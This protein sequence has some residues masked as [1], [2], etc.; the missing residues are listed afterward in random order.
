MRTRVWFVVG[1]TVLFGS[2]DMSEAYTIFHRKQVDFWGGQ[3]YPSASDPGA[4]QL[5]GPGIATDGGGLMGAWT[6][7][8]WVKGNL[9]V[10]VM[11]SGLFADMDVASGPLGISSNMVMLSSFLGGLRYDLAH[12]NAPISPYVTAVVGPTFG[13][14]MRTDIGAQTLKGTPVHQ[15]G[16][17]AALGGRLGGGVD[18]RLGEH[19]RLGVNAGYH[20]KSSF[21]GFLGGRRDYSGVEVGVGIGRSW[22][23]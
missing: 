4:S 18:I 14:S 10:T 17:G 2:F 20:L 13:F 19:W 11:L 8:Y 21:S 3:W 1:L 6:Y 5:I 15:P 12:A 22:G 7:T 9:A 23:N 16:A